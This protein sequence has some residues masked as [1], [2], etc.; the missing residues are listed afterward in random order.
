MRPVALVTGGSK[1]IGRAIAL[2]LARAHHDVAIVYRSDR[3]A[4]MAVGQAIEA[5]GVSAQLIQHDVTC[6]DAVE[7]TVQAVVRQFDRLDVLVNNVG[8]FFFKPLA[9][10]SDAE[11]QHVIHSNLSSVFYACRRVIPIMR[12]QRKGNIVNIGLSP[13]YAVRGAAN[14]CAYSI[15][16][17]GVLILSRS[18]ASEEAAHGIRVNCVSPGL[19][20]NGFLPQAQREWMQQRVPTG[21]LGRPED[22]AQAVQFLVSDKA[23]YVSGANL[24]VS[25]AWDWEDRPSDH[26]GHVHDLFVAGAAD[27]SDE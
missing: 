13:N 17:T 15:A 18:L 22:I 14:V 20:D 2:E 10:M 4:A 5:Q 26:D 23:A 1:G 19:I 27:A 3:E 16:K 24:A 9:Q 21:R 8:E 11:W 6:P 12:R 7:A 25:G